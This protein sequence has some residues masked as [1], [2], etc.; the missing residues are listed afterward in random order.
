MI[1]IENQPNKVRVHSDSGD[2]MPSIIFKAQLNRISHNPEKD[3]LIIYFSNDRLLIS[4]L[5]IEQ[6]QRDELGINSNADLM[7]YFDSI[8]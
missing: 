6:A 4:Y 2:Y 3:Y 5:M 7:N 8:T 1:R